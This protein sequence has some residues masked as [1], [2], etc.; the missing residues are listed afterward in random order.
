MVLNFASILK[1]KDTYIRFISV[2]LNGISQSE[3]LGSSQGNQ[4][5]QPTHNPGHLSH[6][7]LILWQGKR[8]SSKKTSETRNI[9]FLSYGRTVSKQVLCQ[10]YLLPVTTSFAA[11]RVTIAFFKHMSMLRFMNKTMTFHYST[12]KAVQS[13]S[14]CIPL[15]SLQTK[16]LIKLLWSLH[17]TRAC[18]AAGKGPGPAPSLKNGII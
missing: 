5:H 6:G 2:K 9:R 13:T 10:W 16:R 15:R 11:P 4:I 1:S 18:T 3:R 17:Q 14:I 7:R 8:T 12:G